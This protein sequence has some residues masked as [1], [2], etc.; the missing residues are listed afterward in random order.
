MLLLVNNTSQVSVTT[1][2]SS[3]GGYALHLHASY[4]NNVSGVYTPLEA[5]DIIASATSFGI[6]AAP[7]SGQH[8][9]RRLEA[10]N[11][12]ATDSCRVVITVFDGTTTTT[13][14]AG[15][16]LAGESVILDNNGLPTKYAANGIAVTSAPVAVSCSPS[17][18][19]LRLT[20]QTG[21]SIPNADVASSTSIFFTPHEHGSIALFDGTN[22]NERITTEVSLALGTV[23]SGF[24]YDVFAVWL[25]GAVVLEIA[26]WATDTTRTT[27]I[28]RVNGVLVKTSDPLRRYVGTFRTISTTQTTDTRT[29]R[30]IYNEN[31]QVDR[32]LTQT[33]ATTTW[34]YALT[35]LRQAR[36]TT[37]NKVEVVVGG[38]VSRPFHCEVNASCLSSSAASGINYVGKDSITVAAGL[39]ASITNLNIITTSNIN[40]NN[41]AKLDD[42]MAI[43]YHFLTWLEACT[44]AS[45]ITFTGTSTLANG[46]ITSSIRASFKM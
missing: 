9:V 24:N 15:T 37:T 19:G 39:N 33:D 27:A 8:N 14:W 6:V 1:S 42:V 2:A 40:T 38:L 44:A 41:N 10:Y 43:G 7:T 5:S 22:W 36:A 25:S 23:V 13:H 4:V 31:N 16:L 35:T 45:S 21:N 11:A 12:H 18:Q 46:N 29:Q 30:Y 28:S 34:T 32:Y 17:I 20:I 26:Q 3:G